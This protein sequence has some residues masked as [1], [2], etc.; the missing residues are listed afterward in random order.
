MLAKINM[1]I[2]G[3]GI[4][5]KAVLR[6]YR[7][8]PHCTLNSLKGFVYSEVCLKFQRKMFICPRI[9]IEICLVE[10]M[11]SYFLTRYILDYM[12]NIQELKPRNKPKPCFVKIFR[13]YQD[14]PVTLE[15]MRNQIVWLSKLHELVVVFTELVKGECTEFLFETRNS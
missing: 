9:V 13:H 12:Q 1:N 14:A 8:D 2:Y 15:V 6:N 11:V 3:K 10:T 7:Y 5:S 4:C